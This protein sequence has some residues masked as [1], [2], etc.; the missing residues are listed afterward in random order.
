MRDHNFCRVDG[1][2]DGA[3]REVAID[4]FN[5]VGSSIQIFLLSTRAGGLG[6]E[7][8]PFLHM[9]VSRLMFFS[10]CN[11]LLLRFA[12]AFVTGINLCSADTV[13]LYDSD[14]NPQMDLQAQDRAHRIGQTKPVKVYRLISEK[15]IEEKVLERALGKLRLD[16]LVIQQGRLGGEHEDQQR[17][18]IS[19]AEMA[20]A[21]RFGAGSI[22]SSQATAAA[23]VAGTGAGAGTGGGGG[24]AAAADVDVDAILANAEVRTKE[25]NSKLL[26]QTEQ[27]LLDGGDSGG[28][29]DWAFDADDTEADEESLRCEQ[30]RQEV[31]QLAGARQKRQRKQVVRMNMIS[32]G[33]ELSR[34]RNNDLDDSDMS[35][36]GSSQSDDS[37]EE[38]DA[39]RSYS[40]AKR[41]KQRKKRKKSEASS[42]E[43]EGPISGVD[44]DLPPGWKSGLYEPPGNREAIRFFFHV[45]DKD[46][47]QWDHPDPSYAATKLK[48]EPQPQHPQPQPQP[49]KPDVVDLTQS[50]P[51]QQRPLRQQ[52]KQS[53]P[54]QHRGQAAAGLRVYDCQSREMT[55]E[56]RRLPKDWDVQYYHDGTPFYVHR[57]TN[58][59]TWLPPPL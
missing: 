28:I 45:S 13:V 29:G 3:D 21:V 27:T 51:Q 49:Q 42:S 38:D 4:A 15:S 44:D 43:D 17:S 16:T 26:A 20:A 33:E 39:H 48:T 41:S 1:S 52:Q 30:E 2:T 57:Q 24:V 35:E 55:V 37:S 9:V 46:N 34:R 19:R 40:Y 5:A 6:T 14:W 31:M 11:S 58:E 25:M 7:I 59:T 12:T 23:P 8:C 56:K 32:H 47:P 22:L 50:Q 36:P 18:T 54:Q 10:L 53:R